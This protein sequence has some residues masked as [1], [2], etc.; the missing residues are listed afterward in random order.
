MAPSF[1]ERSAI[2]EDTLN[3]TDTILSEVPE[4]S[5]ESRF[6][7]EQLPPLDASKCPN[8]PPTKVVVDNADSFTTARN[9]IKRSPQ[10]TRKTAVLNLA[11]DELQAGGWLYSLAKTQEE[12]LCYSSTLY[13][14]LKEEYY[15]WPN[16]GPGSV[17][18]IYSPAVVIFKDDLDHNCVDLSPQER[19][20]VSVLTVA[21][22]RGP[23]LTRDRTA[24]KYPQDL[25]DMRGKIR[26]VYRMAAHNGNTHIVLGAMGC[27][28]YYCPPRQVAEEMRNILLEPEFKGWFQE[29]VFA[30]YATPG[31][32]NFEVFSEVFE[33]V[34]V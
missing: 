21:A 20:V 26:L 7:A 5:S 14:T 10:A 9:I 6:I 15:P 25:E 1:R 31:N 4:G 32:P 34:E 22:P 17:A 16:L 12:A 8:Y 11:S 3:R 27:G 2:S 28:A 30:V 19:Q 33:D 23:R 24:F 29:I 18:G 13:A